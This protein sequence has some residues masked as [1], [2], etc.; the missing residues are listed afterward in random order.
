MEI[1]LATFLF[2][3]ALLLVPIILSW[4]K[5]KCHLRE[6]AAIDSYQDRL[7]L[8]NEYKELTGVSVVVYKGRHDMRLP[9]GSF[10][11]FISVA[12]LKSRIRNSK[13]DSYDKQ[14]TKIVELQAR[15][16]YLQEINEA[17]A[18]R[19]EIL[20]TPRLPLSIDYPEVTYTAEVR[21]PSKAKKQRRKK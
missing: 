19:I 1:G 2:V 13:A 15:V 6:H 3:T 11:V 20:L 16:N 21:T 4:W 14:K 10:S 18:K 12:E 17:N 9:P 7:K 5:F 8:A